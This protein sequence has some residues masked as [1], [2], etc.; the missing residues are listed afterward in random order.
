MFSDKQLEV[1]NSNL[2]SNRIKTR[3]KGN[4]T[5]SY[6]EGH[7]IIET[8]NRIFGYGNWEYTISSLEMV[9]QE[10]NQ[11]Q[12]HIICYKAV[13]KV[14]V[15]N[16]THTKQIAREDVGFGSGIAKTQADAHEG[17]AKEAVTDCLKRS[18]KSYGSQMGLS[19]YDKTKNHNS[20]SQQYNN[21]TQNY[22]QTPNNQ[23]QQNYHVPQNQSIQNNDSPQDYGQLTHIGLSVMQQ[24]QNYIVVGDSDTIFANK[25]LLRNQFN[26]RWD[27]TNKVW[28][29]PIEQQAA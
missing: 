9:S 14:I 26:F 20:N 12:N 19:L 25:S 24:G 5:L 3:N 23:N 6:L 10:L 13:V 22:N 7:D 15:Y 18:L 4:I 11:N 1:L 27:G 21:N 2:N 28:W 8:A 17:G 16:D 29:K